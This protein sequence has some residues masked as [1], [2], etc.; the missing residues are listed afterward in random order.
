MRAAMALLCGGL[1]GAA[2][3]HVRVDGDDAAAGSS[4]AAAFRTIPKALQMARGGDTVWL[5][6]GTHYHEQILIQNIPNIAADRRLAIRAVVPHGTTISAAWPEAARGALAWR[7][8]GDGIYSAPQ[9]Q[10]DGT[11]LRSAMGGHGQHLLPVWSTLAQLRGSFCTFN[12]KHGNGRESFR[13][14]GYGFAQDGGRTYVRLPGL[15]DPNGA[16]VVLSYGHFQ[17]KPSMRELIRIVG[18]PGVLIDGVRFEG[19][20]VAIACD[21]ASTHAVVRNCWFQ[22]CHIGMKLASHSVAEWNDFGY[23][24]LKKLIDE[25]QAI[26]KVPFDGGMIFSF[27]YTPT[28]IFGYHAKAVN[29]TTTHVTLRYNRIADAWDGD[30]LGSF[31]A[32]Q[33]HGSIYQDCID[34]AIEFDD[35]PGVDL[36]LHH[37]L[38]LGC[39]NGVISHQRPEGAIQGPQYIYR[40]VIVGYSDPGWTSWTVV[41]L[42]AKGATKGIYYHHNLIW[43]K[44]A[45]L[46]WGGFE[47]NPDWL[48]ATRSMDWRNNVLIFDSLGLPGNVPFPASRNVVIGAAG[49]KPRI[50][51]PGGFSLADMADARFGDAS[52][53]DFVPRTGSRLINAG[54]TATAAALTRTQTEVKDGSPDIGPFEAGSTAGPDWPRPRRRVVN[55]APYRPDGG[56]LDLVVRDADPTLVVSRLVNLGGI[57]PEGVAEV[58]V[59]GA[60]APVSEGR[61]S[62]TLALIGAPVPATV[63]FIAPDGSRRERVFLVGL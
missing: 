13:T 9:R 30:M 21:A 11:P 44:S 10:V 46:Y 57:A 12:A 35:A 38:F 51:G 56:T 26:N 62:T 28:W 37:N 40:N 22:W 32:S 1:L 17:D 3:W 23:T 42:R 7:A 27:G 45:P 16:P 63:A 47:S 48:A 4:T 29:A 49:D 31:T 36:A 19:A 58:R 18:S 25:C 52:F 43:M 53:Y 61:W 33:A 24:G 50:Q 5:H 8:E 20:H 55:R 6:P 34:N 15:A 2:E 14:P 39:A 54:L 41:K 59:N 60:V